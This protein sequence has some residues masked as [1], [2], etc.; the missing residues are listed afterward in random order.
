HATNEQVQA[1]A[2][3]TYLIYLSMMYK[4]V[5]PTPSPTPTKTAIPPTGVNYDAIPVDPYSAPDRIDSQHADWNLDLRG[6]ALTNADL[7]LVDYNGHTDA[8]PPRLANLFSPAR[9]PVFTAAYKVYDWIWAPPPDPGDRGSLLSVWPVTLLWMKASEGELIYLPYRTPD[10]Y[11]GRYHALVLYATSNQITL[12]YTRDGTVA[13][14]YTVHIVNIWVDPA[15]VALY[16]QCNR[17]GRHYL[18]GLANGQPI[19]RAKVGG[20]GVAVRDHGTFM[21]PRSRKDWW[22]GW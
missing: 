8:D 13:N 9:L 16:Q 22:P 19:G 20:I 12:A 7:R 10:I 15:L 1:R 2:T 17:D 14:G 4:E 3:G 5:T 21:D 6:Y 18:P 11:Q